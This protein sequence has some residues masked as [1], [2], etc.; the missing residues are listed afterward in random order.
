MD[1]WATEEF[2]GAQLGD[3]RLTKRLVKIA[4]HFAGQPTASLPGAC[5]DGA[6][7]QATYRFFDQ[8]REE[9][10]GLGWEDLLGPHIACTQ[11]RMRQHPVVLCLQD[12]TELDLNG[13]AIEG[14]GPLSYE[15]QRGLYLHPTYVVTPQREPLGV[16]DAWIWA[17]EFKDADGTRPGILESTRW[18]EGY[19]RVA[20]I[21]TTLPDT[22]LV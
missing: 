5:P 20:E 14:L 7:T 6:E 8:A 15:A 22:R 1:T 9:K 13:Q 4:T 16:V 12:T 2:G 10:Q 18:S 21:A 3:A 17:R 11:A 19:E